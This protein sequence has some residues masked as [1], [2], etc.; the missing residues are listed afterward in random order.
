M[1]VDLSQVFPDAE[2]LEK[3]TQEALALQSAPLSEETESG[4]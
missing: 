2:A 4:K 3:M 1:K